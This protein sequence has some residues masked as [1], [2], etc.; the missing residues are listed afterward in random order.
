MTE[1]FSMKLPTNRPNISDGKIFFDQI[2]IAMVIMGGKIESQVL[3][4]F[5]LQ[6]LKQVEFSILAAHLICQ[7]SVTLARRSRELTLVSQPLPDE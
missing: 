2:A 7:G 3:S 6:R 5:D 4:I 1:G